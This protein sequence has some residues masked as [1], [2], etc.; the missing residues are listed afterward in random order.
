MV[1]VKESLLDEINY[2]CRICSR[3][4]RMSKR[5]SPSLATLELIQNPGADSC[6]EESFGDIYL[7]EKKEES[8]VA[9]S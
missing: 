2:S 5:L 3:K 4:P 9:Q 7:M 1:I 8:Q 6:A